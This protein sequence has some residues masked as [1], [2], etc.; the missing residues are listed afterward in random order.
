MRSLDGATVSCQRFGA[1]PA[2]HRHTQ[3]IRLKLASSESFPSF[4]LDRAVTWVTYTHTHTTTTGNQFFF[5]RSCLVL[6]ESHTL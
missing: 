1:D 3:C 5:V 6:A 2:P 4:S